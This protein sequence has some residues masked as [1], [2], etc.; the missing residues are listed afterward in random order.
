MAIPKKDSPFPAPAEERIGSGD[1]GGPTGPERPGEAKRRWY[2]I[3]DQAR[4]RA[5]WAL[6]YFQ[7]HFPFGRI[8]KLH[9]I[10]ARERYWTLMRVLDYQREI[11]PAEQDLERDVAL[12]ITA[13]VMDNVKYLLTR[14]HEATNRLWR[15]MT[16]VRV[17]LIQHVLS[18][19]DLCEQVE[20]FREEMF[21][22]RV[23]TDPTVAAHLERIQDSLDARGTVGENHRS[24]VRA[25]VGGF[26]RLNTIRTDRIRQ[27]YLNIRTYWALL[28]I[29]VPTSLALL[30][31]H[32]VVTA[33]VDRPLADKLADIGFTQSAVEAINSQ[34][35]AG[36]LPIAARAIDSQVKDLSLPTATDVPAGETPGVKDTPWYATMQERLAPKNNVLVF[37]FFGGFLGGIFSAIMRVRSK[38]LLPGDDAY[39]AWYVCTKPVVGALGAVIIFLLING[40]LVAYEVL[41]SGALLAANVK[42][43]GIAILSGFSERLVLPNLR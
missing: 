26:Q 9:Y 11:P 5:K 1:L 33:P 23:D 30:W 20:E 38:E 31:F 39:F 24:L 25:L 18:K 12:K 41:G 36:T 29:V 27:Q 28:L 10:E 15:A 6:M 13:S 2:Q 37:V 32:A 43:F 3:S 22:L 7:R 21:R 8:S 19:P 16:R 35:E 17:I 34:V 40:G 4:D 14:S 42:T